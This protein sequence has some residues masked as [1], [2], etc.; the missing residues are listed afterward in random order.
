MLEK[1]QKRI[2]NHRRVRAKIAWTASRPRLAVFR[3]NTWIYA[4]IIDDVE[5]KTLASASDLKIKEGTKTQRAEKVWEEI[6]KI[7][8]SLKITKIVFDKWGFA[9]HGRVKALAESARKAGLEF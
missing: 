5:G 3:S 2:K 6:A 4:Q 9:Y 7:A 8:N 1:V